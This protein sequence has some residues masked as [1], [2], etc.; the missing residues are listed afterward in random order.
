VPE[1]LR[2]FSYV[3]SMRDVAAL[4]AIERTGRFAAHDGNCDMDLAGRLQLGVIDRQLAKLTQ[5]P[6][7]DDLKRLQVRWALPTRAFATGVCGDP[8]TDDNHQS[9]TPAASVGRVG[10]ER[11]CGQGPEAGGE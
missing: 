5:T 8:L 4:T 6:L 11:E 3:L 7:A 1:A 9:H 2:L 10:P